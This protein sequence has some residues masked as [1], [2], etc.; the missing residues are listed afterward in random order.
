MKIYTR[1]GD[2]GEASLFGGDRVAKDS[3]RLEAYGTVDELNSFLGLARSL[4]D[5]IGQEIDNMLDEIQSDLLVLGADLAAPSS[6]EKSR[7]PRIESKDVE[8]LERWID[9]YEEELTPLKNFILPGGSQA[10]SALHLARTVCR[11]AERRVV[12]LSHSEEVGESALAY[13][14]RLSDLLFV[15]ARLANGRAGVEEVK[16]NPPDRGPINDQ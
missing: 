1:K 3:L 10:A 8:R 4:Q 6:K 12:T 7:T 15:L 9:K 16:W 14:N 2:G 13:I 5:S 11:R